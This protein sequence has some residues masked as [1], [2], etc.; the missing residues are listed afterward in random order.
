VSDIAQDLRY[1]VRTLRRSPGFALVAVLTLALGIGA[2]TAIFSVVYAVLLHPL[3]FKNA[4]RLVRLY[5]N[6]PAAESPNGKPLRRGN[7]DVRELL[8]LRERSQR[9]SHVATYGIAIVSAQG[10]TDA[11]RQILASVSA[12]AF[13]MLGVPPLIGRW[14]TTDDDTPGRDRIILISYGVWQRYFGGDPQVLGRTLTFNGNNFGASMTYG[15]AYTVVGVMPPGFH[16]PDDSAQ[17]WVPF[18]LAP[19]ADGR[20]HG[21]AMMARLADGAS[22]DAAAAE[23][24]TIVQDIRGRSWGPARF[25]LVRVQDE[26]NAS[27]RPALVVLMM[28]V[29]FVL[30]IACANVANLLLVRT[31]ARQRE[32]AIRAAVGASHGRLIRQTLTESVLL[33]LLG[34]G[35]GTLLAF[36]GIRLFRGLAAGLSRLD[37]GSSV[38]AF[39]RLDAIGINPEAFAFAMLVSVVTGVL[40]GLAPALRGAQPERI[41]V[42][43]RDAVHAVLV[44]AETALA[45]LLFV[46]GGLLMHSFVKLAEVHLGFDPVNVLT[47]QVSLPGDR[48]PAAQLTA[49]SEDL[50]A[51]LGSVPGV[52]AA[53]YANQLPLVQIRNSISVRT[54]A[55]PPPPL[56]AD[57]PDVRL[58]SRNYTEA[59][60]IR[61]M[62]GRGFA[63]SD[64]AGRPRVLL[65]NQTLARRDFSGRVPVGETVY[66]GRDTTPWQIVGIVEDVRQSGLDQEPRP[67]LFAD[68]RQ[69]PGPGV[70]MFPLGAY[71]VVRA[72][73]AASV[74][75]IARDIVGQLE[76]QSALDNVATMEQVVSNALTLP[77][78]YSVLL[79]IFAGVAV[80]LAAVGIYG[81]MAYSV[82]QRTREIGIRMALGAQRAQVL[83]LVLRKGAI[84]T[85]TGIA[86]G[87]AG[88]AAGTRVLQGMLFGITPLDPLTF[89]A[90]SLLFGLVA[91]VASYLPARRATTVDPIVA[92]R[93]E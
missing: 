35:A 19:A 8:G 46:G 50:V 48:R 72:A 7:M 32:M 80:T 82:T 44:I 41:T 4:E 90:V 37:L 70:P 63:E 33:S 66:L 58:V 30:L 52:R 15:V 38:A 47:F 26:V 34:G 3:P 59:M 73:D 60:G 69:W 62:A 55:A 56:M 31:A 2:N 77:R 6:V 29:V 76:P 12:A 79:G 89:A 28:A 1:A 20:P 53:A 13:P 43:K 78:M 67:Q 81:V 27:V 45:I 71:Y 36:G 54:T 22:P 91:T 23:L 68:F 57:A 10:S 11:S 16:F 25:E 93:S 40:F 42:A 74:I 21:T 17:F 86:L 14:F 18:A 64:G 92:L 65:I 9:L 49:F 51:R 83:G 39:P 87:L 5:E 75:P 61:V 88:A 85:A 24:S 84:L